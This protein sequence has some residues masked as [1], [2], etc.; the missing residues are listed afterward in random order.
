MHLNSFS[1]GDA[2]SWELVRTEPGLVQS[3][4]WRSQPTVQ[5]EGMA[6]IL[7][8]DLWLCIS[9]FIKLELKHLQQCL[10]IAV[11]HQLQHC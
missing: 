3:Q 2:M 1:A 5:K 7:C 10:Q 6:A 8:F 11:L 4:P 9:T